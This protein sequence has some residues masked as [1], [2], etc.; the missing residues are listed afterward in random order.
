MALAPHAATN[1]NPK[2]QS[3]TPNPTTT[4]QPPKIHNPQAQQPSQ[5]P[6]SLTN[7]K[8]E[9]VEQIFDPR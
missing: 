1:P 5:Q 3:P 2:P 8:S 7:P 9:T 4:Q 6:R